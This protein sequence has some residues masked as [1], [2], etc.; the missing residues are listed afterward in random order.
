MEASCPQAFAGPSHCSPHRQS[1][2]VEGRGCLESF[3]I[4]LSLQEAC[5]SKRKA[6]LETTHV[7]HAPRA[8]KQV[9][10]VSPLASKASLRPI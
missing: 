4:G 8:G 5:E 9:V 2:V 6:G 1:Q 3:T 7:C 10:E